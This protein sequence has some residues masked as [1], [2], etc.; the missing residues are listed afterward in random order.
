VIDIY[1]EKTNHPE[2]RISHAGRYAAGGGRG[3]YPFSPAILRSWAA[4][5]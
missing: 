4:D 2:I 3:V 1:H 5:V